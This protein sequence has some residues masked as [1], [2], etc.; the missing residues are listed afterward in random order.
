MPSCA[1]MEL[2]AV[3]DTRRML[4]PS[5]KH[6]LSSK[7][8]LLTGVKHLLDKSLSN[9]LTRMLLKSQIE[10]ELAIR[11][12]PRLPL[13]GDRTFLGINQGVNRGICYR[14]PSPRAET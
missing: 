13:G 7:S 11:R 12:G 14:N 1:V 4:P 6:G 2:T 3:R 5:H 8:G 9:R 10:V